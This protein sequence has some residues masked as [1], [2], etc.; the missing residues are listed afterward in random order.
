MCT[1][2]QEDKGEDIP[3][4]SRLPLVLLL[5]VR[6]EVLLL[7][8]LLLLLLVCCVRLLLLEGQSHCLLLEGRSTEH[9]EEVLRPRS[10]RVHRR[11][12]LGERRQPKGDRSL[13]QRR[14]SS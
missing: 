9:A 10:E 1:R 4:R 3:E 5:L 13:L 8:L 11:R 2:K 14:R 7:L 6:G 12:P